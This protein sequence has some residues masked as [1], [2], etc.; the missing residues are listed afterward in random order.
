MARRTVQP[1]SSAA[2]ARWF[3]FFS[4]S[5]VLFVDRAREDDERTQ[6]AALAPRCVMVWRRRG[7]LGLGVESS[8]ASVVGFV[9]VERL[10]VVVV[11]YGL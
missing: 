7:F 10:R 6:L 5:S 4:L 1:F 3:A 8:A 11:V 9:F 2:A